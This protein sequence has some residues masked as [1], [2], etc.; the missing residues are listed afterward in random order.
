[1]AD[2]TPD[3]I[4]RIAMDFMVAKH[5]FISGEGLAH[6]EGD[7]EG[8]LRD[9]GWRKSERRRLGGP[10]SVIIAEAI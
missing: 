1:M 5:L 4:M 3:P 2:V 8:W 7:A 10:H 9:T 6:G